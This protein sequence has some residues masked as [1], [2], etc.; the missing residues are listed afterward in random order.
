LLSYAD[1]VLSGAR[2][3]LLPTLVV[4]GAGAIGRVRAVGPDAT[5]L[6]PGECVFCDPTVRSRD[7]APTP[8]ITLQGA[9]A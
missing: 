2:R 1:E 5:R 3:Y 8:D 9:S 6:Q 7:G 4:P